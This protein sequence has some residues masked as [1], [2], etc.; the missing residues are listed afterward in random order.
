MKEASHVSSSRE[1]RMKR[2]RG[3]GS[4]EGGDKQGTQ[5]KK[6]KAES[7]DCSGPYI[8]RALGT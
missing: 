3:A 5:E 8:G 4:H 2:G 7:T 1:T 6:F